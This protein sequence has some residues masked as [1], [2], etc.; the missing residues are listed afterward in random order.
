MH[1]LST[2]E[3][4]WLSK[5]RVGEVRIVFTEP[6]NPLER[7]KVSMFPPRANEEVRVDITDYEPGV[8]ITQ[9]EVFIGKTK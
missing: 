1:A 3:R 9:G 2:S 4:R 8:L 6:S 5:A 7:R